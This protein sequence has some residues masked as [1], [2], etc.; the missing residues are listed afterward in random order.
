M[1]TPQ[2]TLERL[3]H[4]SPRFL[5]MRTFGSSPGHPSD[6]SLGCVSS[7]RSGEDGRHQRAMNCCA[8]LGRLL[9]SHA[10]RRSLG[11]VGTRCESATPRERPVYFRFQRE[12]KKGPDKNN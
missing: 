2:R 12:A 7:P 9:F 4:I 6:R 3:A 1:S 8:L 11:D 5:A 10:G